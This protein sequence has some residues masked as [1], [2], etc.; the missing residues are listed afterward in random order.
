MG[1]RIDGLKTDFDALASTRQRALEKPLARIADLR[2]A[3]ANGDGEAAGVDDRQLP[4]DAMGAVEIDEA[5][6]G[7]PDSAR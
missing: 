4:L 7:S 3:V 5:E 6:E 2:G 1:R